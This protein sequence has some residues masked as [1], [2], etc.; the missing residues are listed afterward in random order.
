[1]PSPIFISRP[2][3]GFS[4]AAIIRGFQLTFL[5]AYRAL[6]NR[7]LWRGAYFKKALV[8][9][10]FSVIINI[11][12]WLPLLLIKHTLLFAAY[13]FGSSQGG[14][15]DNIVSTLKFMQT[16]VFNLGPFLIQAYRYFRPE[17]DEMFFSSL[18]FI[19]SVYLSKHP[20]TD[21]LY[22]PALKK[23]SSRSEIASGKKGNHWV[24]KLVGL[25]VTSEG[26]VGF[27]HSY[28]K[29]SLMSFAI[30]SVANIP[31]FGPIAVSA[32]SFYNF[33]KEVGTIAALFVFSMGLIV[34]QRWLVIFL[35]GYW[36]SRSL[37][38]ELLTPYFSRLLFTRSEKEKWFKARQGIMFGF[39]VGFY[40]LLRIPF[41]GI[42]IYGLAEA[43]SAYLITKVTDPPPA[44][45]LAVHWAETQTVWTRQNEVISG[46]DLVDDGFG[47]AMIGSWVNS[48]KIV[49]KNR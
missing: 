38:R 47:A 34:P 45:A 2:S 46:S 5:G 23:Y 12:L 8:A 29:R 10:I 22:S 37:V 40:L 32:Y 42:V 41:V 15:I 35:T 4:L 44:P 14:K 16:H 28:F 43:S 21:R 18:E 31:F 3:A 1:M 36:G 33:N 7:K 17:V 24:R 9:I 6:M 39:G 48:E 49:S 11:L 25:N 19:D 30:Y 20:N 27:L 26:F 13:I